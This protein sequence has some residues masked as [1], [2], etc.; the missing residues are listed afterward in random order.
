MHIVFVPKGEFTVFSW[1]DTDGF[2][3]WYPLVSMLS[4]TTPFSHMLGGLSTAC[5]NSCAHIHTLSASRKD[6]LTETIVPKLGHPRGRKFVLSHILIHQP[7]KLPYWELWGSSK[8]MA[9]NRASQ[10]SPAS[11]LIRESMLV[12]Y[13]NVT[14]VPVPNC[15]LRGNPDYYTGIFASRFS[16]YTPFSQ[17]LA[18]MCTCV[19]IFWGLT[20]D[21]AIDLFS[22]LCPQSLTEHPSSTG[23]YVNWTIFYY[24]L[25]FSPQSALGIHVPIWAYLIHLRLTC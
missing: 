12:K 2:L 24:S 19:S 6:F 21:Q 10:I 14:E 23:F 17:T 4:Y 11:V 13:P 25:L 16:E 3:S 7:W 1:L 18:W 5:P 20:E 22:K 8:D 15:G 9:R